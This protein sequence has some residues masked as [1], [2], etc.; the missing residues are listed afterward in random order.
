[1]SEMVI[2]FLV[3]GVVVSLFAMLGDVLRPMSFAGLFGAA[4]SIALATVSLT[5]HKEG[6]LYAAAEAKTMILGAAAF[7]VYAAL[8]SLIL[9]RRRRS[10]LATALVLM[11]VW[12]GISFGLCLTLAGRL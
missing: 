8:A 9:R 12:F 3:G 11:P 7:L 2:R 1:M 10:T 5:I 4:P 6:R